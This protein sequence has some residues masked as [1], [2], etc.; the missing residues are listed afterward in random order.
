MILN[1]SCHLFNRTVTSS[2]AQE[3]AATSETNKENTSPAAKKS[4]SKNN[5]NESEVT[6]TTTHGDEEFQVKLEASFTHG[7]GTSVVEC[8]ARDR[9]AAGLSLTGVTALWSLRKT[10]LS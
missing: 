4:G 7:I 9:R 1:F 8:L 10:H 6:S 2:K 5:A 3:E